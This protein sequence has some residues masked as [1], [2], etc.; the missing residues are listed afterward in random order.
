MRISRGTTS[1]LDELPTENGCCSQ[2][3]YTEKNGCWP[4]NLSPTENGCTPPN[5]T[6]IV[7]NLLLGMGV[8]HPTITLRMM[9]MGH[10]AGDIRKVQREAQDGL[11][12]R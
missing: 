5:Y 2:K 10:G 4:Q 11:C 6:R 3:K 7:G 1:R 9:V 12:S 8:Y